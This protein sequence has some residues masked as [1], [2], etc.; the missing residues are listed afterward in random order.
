MGGR[1]MKETIAIRL[2]ILTR[3]YPECV[4]VVGPRSVRLNCREKAI[5]SALH[6]LRCR[7]VEWN[8][9]FL[10]VSNQHVAY[11]AIAAPLEMTCPVCYAKEEDKMRFSR[12]THYPLAKGQLVNPCRCTVCRDI[13][14]V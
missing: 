8:D 1:R 10:L 11:Q 9:K 12:S 4:E 5:E 6:I 14:E 13:I 2:A 7:L 3:S